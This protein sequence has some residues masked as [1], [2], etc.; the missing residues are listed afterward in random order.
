[1]RFQRTIGKSIAVSGLGI[2]TG[3]PSGITIHPAPSNTGLIFYKVS[4]GVPE[5]CPVSIQCLHQTDLCTSLSHNGFQ[6]QTVEHLLSALSGLEID[7]VY[8]ELDGNEVPALDGSSAPFVEL[9]QEAGIV[10]QPVPRTYVKIVHPISINHGDKSISVHPSSLQKISYSIAYDHP[11]IQSQSYVYSSSPTDFERYIAHARTFAFKSEVEGLWS[12]GL[13]M[14]GTLDNTLVFSDTELLNDAGL[15]YP[16]ECV[17][18]KILDLIGDLAL[19]GLPVIGHFVAER[20]GHQL[21]AELVMAILENPDSWILI[22]TDRTGSDSIPS[23]LPIQE[24][25]LSSLPK[26]QPALSTL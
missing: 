25:V 12:K 20:A 22:N 21:H 13:G 8:L 24:S 7:N 15:R 6:I 1:M 5:A 14:G 17:R 2:H 11:L 18:H 16:D 23:P 26:T 3:T 4:Q 19:L 10:E 9:L